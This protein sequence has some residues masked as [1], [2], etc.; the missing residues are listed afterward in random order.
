M[1][2]KSLLLI[3]KAECLL[4]TVIV[5][6]LYLLKLDY[7]TFHASTLIPVGISLLAGGLLMGTDHN[8]WLTLINNR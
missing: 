4:I 8:Q 5:T 7:L 6:T 2:Q 3:F 1:K